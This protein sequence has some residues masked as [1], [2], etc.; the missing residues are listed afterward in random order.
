M[1]ESTSNL[2]T[3]QLI[4]VPAL[5][6]LGVTLLRLIGELNQWSPVWF[7]REAGGGGALVGIVWL[8]P[9]FGVYF[10]LR[11][12]RAG[13]GP[14]S[15]TR[16]IG[17]AVAGVVLFAVLLMVIA[18]LPSPILVR[19]V[20]INLSAVL[21]ALVVYRGWP[22]LGW[23]EFTYGLA[24]RIP[25]VLVMLIA[26]TAQWG[27]HYELGPPGLPEMGLFPKW[28]AI[29]LIPQLVFWVSF[30]VVVGSLFGSLALLFRRPAEGQRG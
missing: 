6:T 15:R 3:R 4:L 14:K 16:T 7:S 21:S 5:I 10:A 2:S 25:V 20:L 26:M 1:N 17:H 24:A 13:R 27:T 22:D 8:V 11:L 23:T 29:G 18:N 12:S 30:T 28:L 19:M 9:V